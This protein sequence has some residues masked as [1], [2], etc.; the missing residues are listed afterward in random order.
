MLLLE[1]TNYDQSTIQDNYGAP[2]YS[3]WFVRN[4]FKHVLERVGTRVEIKRPEREVDEIYHAA[5]ARGEDCAFFAFCPPNTTPLGLACPTVPVFAWE[6]D[7]IPTESW[8]ENP[9]EDWSYVLRRTGI[10]MTH[11]KFSAEVVRRTM[12]EDF[13]IWALPAPV[14]E[15]FARP[16]AH[17]R[18]WR[19][20]F[21]LN[22]NGGL[23]I[24]AGDIDLS[25]FRPETP[26][27]D[28]VRALRV[29]DYAVS[30]APQGIS[31]LHLAG[32]VY[33]TILNPYDGRKNWRDLIS[34]FVWAFRNTPTANLIVKL[35]RFDVED[36]IL[37]VLEH[38][39]V[40][41]KFQCKVILI[42]G[43]LSAEA[44]SGLIEATS[45]AVNTSHGEGQCLPLMEYMS[46]G[47]PA[48]APSHTAMA[49]YVSPENAFIIDSELRPAHWPQDERNTVRC[50]HYLIGFRAMVAQ[51]RE[52]YRVARDDPQRYAHMSAAAVEAL[53]GFCSEDLIV[54]RFGGLVRHIR[55][56]RAQPLMAG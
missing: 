1:Y 22:V 26:R 16:E 49:E 18:G 30:V 52:S 29:L 27:P 17:A 23:A 35:T 11:C 15:T 47:C 5:M 10:A 12:G 43:F 48:V 28:A 32:V 31:P 45:F 8:N 2:E 44:Y 9:G 41:G 46:A 51:Y 20:P 38:L 37:P 19:E 50:S 34:G 14:F 13:P 6:Y 33:T 54:E 3:Y 25:L 36:G 56:A 53:R 4:A 21:T 7:T 40:L 24:S 39:S 55:E 42:H